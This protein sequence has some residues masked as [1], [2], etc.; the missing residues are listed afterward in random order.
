MRWEGGG[1]RSTT[2]SNILKSPQMSSHPTLVLPQISS[3]LLKSPHTPSLLLP[4]ISSNLLTPPFCCFLKSPQTSSNFLKLPQPGSTT[5][6][7]LKFP[8]TSS[9]L[10][11]VQLRCASDLNSVRLKS[12]QISSRPTG[13]AHDEKTI[14]S[15]VGIWGGSGWVAGWL[16]G[17][18]GGQA[19][20]QPGGQAGRQAGRQ[21]GHQA[22]QRAA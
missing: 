15:R 5:S 6:N 9:N 8:Q 10:L 3:N 2:A 7:F 19:G 11:T 14:A 22:R 12:P 1:R 13:S 4:Q 18:I 16:V 20:K 17:S 21:A